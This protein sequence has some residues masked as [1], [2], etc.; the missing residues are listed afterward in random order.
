MSIS[1]WD[2]LWL[3]G[4]LAEYRKIERDFV[5]ADNNISISDKTKFLEKSFNHSLLGEDSQHMRQQ[6]ELFRKK[7]HDSVFADTSLSWRDKEL[8]FKD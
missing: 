8:F 1:P 5:L 6:Y 7:L 4:K 3:Y 2:Y